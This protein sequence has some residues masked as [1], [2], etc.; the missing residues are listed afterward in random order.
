MKS[1]NSTILVYATKFL[2]IVSS[3]EPVKKESVK[4]ATSP[5]AEK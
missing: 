1:K 3:L 2:E 4:E 5:K